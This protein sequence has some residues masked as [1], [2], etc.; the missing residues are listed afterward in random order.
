M[1]DIFDDNRDDN[2]PRNMYAHTRNAANVLLVVYGEEV[3]RITVTA[4]TAAYDSR[5]PLQRKQFVID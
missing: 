4:I 1:D 2:S 5:N 3:I